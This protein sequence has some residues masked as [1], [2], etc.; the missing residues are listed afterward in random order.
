MANPGPVQDALHPKV[1]IKSKAFT[2]WAN[3]LR[4]VK[5]LTL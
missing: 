5:D 2:T 4:L 3:P 1:A